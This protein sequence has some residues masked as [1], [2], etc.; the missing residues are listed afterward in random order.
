MSLSSSDYE[1]FRRLSAVLKRNYR[2]TALFAFYLSHCPEWMEKKTVDA[3][4][5]DGAFSEKEAV[6]ALLA[7]ALG[8]DVGGDAEDRILYRDYL[9]P[10]VRTVRT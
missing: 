2:L 1:K 6:A 10:A 4:T 9:F 7:E 5:K 8:I 3:L